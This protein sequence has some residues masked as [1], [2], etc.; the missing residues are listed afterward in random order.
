MNATVYAP[1]RL[2]SWMISVCK[3]PSD[4]PV[5]CAGQRAGSDRNL[6]TARQLGMKTIRKYVSLPCFTVASCP[7]RCTRWGHAGGCAR[8]G[9]VVRDRSDESIGRQSKALTRMYSDHTC[10]AVVQYSNAF[11]CIIIICRMS[12]AIRKVYRLPESYPQNSP[13]AVGMQAVR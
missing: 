5:R 8:A 1:T 11:Y 3:C 9:N 12:M 10:C 6:K 2:Y 7:T 13:L 4:S